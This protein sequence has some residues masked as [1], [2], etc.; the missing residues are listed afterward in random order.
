MT[1]YLFT[2]H[3]WLY[4]KLPKDGL[5]ALFIVKAGGTSTVPGSQVFGKYL[6]SDGLSSHVSRLSLGDACVAESGGHLRRP[7]QGCPPSHPHPGEHLQI[8]GI[9]REVA[10]DAGQLLVGAVHNGALAATLLGAH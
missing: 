10:G 2:M 8:S 5:S 6:Q 3:L 4:C 9:F 1:S 7:W